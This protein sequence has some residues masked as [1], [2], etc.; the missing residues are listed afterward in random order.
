MLKINEKCENIVFLSFNENI[1]KRL[2]FN[3]ISFNFIFI[4]LISYF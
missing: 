2:L 3:I 1:L 4:D